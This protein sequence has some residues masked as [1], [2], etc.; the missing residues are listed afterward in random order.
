MAEELF[1]EVR[2]MAGA[3]VGMVLM[4]LWSTVTV[5]VLISVTV[6]ILVST[7]RRLSL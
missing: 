5:T 2:K 1:E 6:A 7:A 3:L 4:G